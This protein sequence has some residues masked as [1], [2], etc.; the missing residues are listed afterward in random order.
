MAL[1]GLLKAGYAGMA[2]AWSGMG[3]LGERCLEV[4]GIGDVEAVLL[5]GCAVNEEE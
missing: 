5:V 4:E 3:I 1:E 2:G